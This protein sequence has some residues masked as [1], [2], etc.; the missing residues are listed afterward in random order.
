MKI[1][2]AEDETAL[3]DAV[4]EILKHKNYVVDAV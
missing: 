2:Y 3:S 1:L 4:T